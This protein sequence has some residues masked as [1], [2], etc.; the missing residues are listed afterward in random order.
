MSPEADVDHAAEGG[1]QPTFISISGQLDAVATSSQRASQ[2]NSRGATPPMEGSTSALDGSAGLQRRSIEQ[3]SVAATAIQA[4]WRAFSH[5]REFLERRER[6]TKVDAIRA[7]LRIEEE[8]KAMARAAAVLREHERRLEAQRQEL[9]LYVNARRVAAETAA[10]RQRIAITR[11]LEVGAKLDALQAHIALHNA[12]SVERI[13]EA[14]EAKRQEKFRFCTTT[15]AFCRALVGARRVR[16]VAERRRA[17]ML[18]EW[19]TNRLREVATRHIQRFFHRTVEVRRAEQ[20]AARKQEAFARRQF[21]NA[22]VAQKFASTVAAQLI[23]RDKARR[24][25]LMQITVLQ[26]LFRGK[27]ARRAAQ[28]I[29]SEQQRRIVVRRHNAACVIQNFVAGSYY[30]RTRRVE[31]ANVV[32]THFDNNRHICA[33]KIQATYRMHSV[34]KKFAAQWRASLTARRDATRRAELEKKHAAEML[35]ATRRIQRAYRGHLAV[36]Q[37]EYRRQCHLRTKIAYLQTAMADH[38]A[39]VLQRLFRVFLAR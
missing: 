12:E 14:R 19:A 13:N 22:V 1:A 39:R 20:I 36:R 26:A 30:Q 2:N 34:G 29:R 5:R 25:L 33:R 24:K 7:E 21:S 31:W 37:R 6:A 16:A 9:A 27:V 10:E 8:A 15:Q 3:Q 32:Q 4:R 28:H 11:V 38:C 35:V 17:R 18:E 23:V